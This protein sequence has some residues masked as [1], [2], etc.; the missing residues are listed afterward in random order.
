ME[1]LHHPRT[2]S[3][4]EFD[5]KQPYVQDIAHKPCGFW[6]SVKG[7]DDW[8]SWCESENFGVGS[9]QHS[10]AVDLVESHT[11]LVIDTARDLVEFT[12]EYATAWRWDRP[13]HKGSILE[14]RQFWPI[15]WPRVALTYGGI[16]VAPYQWGLRMDLHWYYGWDCA[17]GCVW[18]LYQIKSVDRIE[19]VTTM[20]LT[21]DT[22]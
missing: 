17:S 11:V 10:Y 14:H 3:T 20:E 13:L 15:D 1:L 19:P 22:L 12:D 7:P 18:D 5:Q 6:V 21:L 4:F 16:I 9:V 8:K 2:I